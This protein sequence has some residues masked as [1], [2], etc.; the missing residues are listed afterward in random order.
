M[1]LP[2]VPSPL[3]CQPAAY[4][5]TQLS[6]EDRAQAREAEDEGDAQA[7]LIRAPAAKQ[8][9]SRAILAGPL[10]RSRLVPTAAASEHLPLPAARTSSKES[11]SVFRPNQPRVSLLGRPP[12]MCLLCFCYSHR[13]QPG[14]IVLEIAPRWIRRGTPRPVG[15]KP[16][17]RAWVSFS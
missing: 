1:H 6:L 8:S 5:G 9:L 14:F 16:W 7:Y 12:G 13:Q 17:G 10:G 2:R 3:I 11:A 15:S 4:G